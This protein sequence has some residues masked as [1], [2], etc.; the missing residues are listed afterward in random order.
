VDL[1][2]VMR[3]TVYSTKVDRIDWDL[4]KYS[5]WGLIS[6]RSIR[7]TKILKNIFCNVDFKTSKYLI[8]QENTMTLEFK[9]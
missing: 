4:S 7:M 5:N 2:T 6:Q 9:A 3:C 8:C 1:Y